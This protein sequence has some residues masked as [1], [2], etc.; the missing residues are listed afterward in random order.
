[1]DCPVR[2]YADRLSLGGVH[3]P[4]V[5]PSPLARRGARTGSFLL[6]GAPLPP[7]LRAGLVASSGAWE[8]PPVG[9]AGSAAGGNRPVLALLS[10]DLSVGPR[11]R[12]AL[13]K[14]PRVPAG[15]IRGIFGVGR[16][17]HIPEPCVTRRLGEPENADW[18]ARS[19]NF[20]GLPPHH[21]CAGMA[22]GQEPSFPRRENACPDRA[23][24][25]R[26]LGEGAGGAGTGLPGG[27][28]GKAYRTDR[29]G[30]GGLGG[31]PA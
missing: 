29:T 4:R 28:F 9:A 13:G 17:H 24:E 31:G 10:D 7:S 15:G 19:R 23:G 25:H 22:A 11:V 16:A 26:E 12:V 8:P 2:L 27:D 3:R 6:R 18:S 14:I 5:R 30:M 1:M 21:Q 20:A